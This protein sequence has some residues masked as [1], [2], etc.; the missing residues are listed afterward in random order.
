M[1]LTFPQ[2]CF[3]AVPYAHMGNHLHRLNIMANTSPFFFQLVPLASPSAL[4]LIH[5]GV[6][7]IQVGLIRVGDH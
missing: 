2:N 3:S 5:H 1:S 4:Y 6:C 7:D